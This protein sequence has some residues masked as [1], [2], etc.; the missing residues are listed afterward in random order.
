MYC[1]FVFRDFGAIT[2]LLE[3]LLWLTAWRVRNWINTKPPNAIVHINTYGGGSY[4]DHYPYFTTFYQSLC[5]SQ[6]LY[7]RDWLQLLFSGLEQ[8]HRALLWLM[9]CV[10]HACCDK[11][12]ISE[13]WPNGMRTP[14]SLW[15]T[16]TVSM[17]I[18]ITHQL[19]HIII[20][21]VR[22]CYIKQTAS[23][24]VR[25]ANP[26]PVL[27]IAHVLFTWLSMYSTFSLKVWRR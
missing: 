27:D 5:N 6:L 1:M 25:Q 2:A 24:A 21:S 12:S 19:F 7:S 11:F 9:A 22:S 17:L 13:H 26:D 15:I 18:A 3:P 8:L 14:L 4:T 20:N 23:A 10:T 16:W